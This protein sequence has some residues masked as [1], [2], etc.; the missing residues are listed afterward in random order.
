[1]LN[2]D[3]IE[4]VD[5]SREDALPFVKYKHYAKRVPAMSYLYGLYFHGL[6]RGVCIFGSSANRSN[7]T[8]G[9]SKAIE[10]VRLFVDDEVSVHR[11]MTSY[12]LGKCLKR[13]PRGLAVVSYADCHNNHAGYIYQATNWFYC[14]QGQ[15]KNGR[16]D[17][18]VTSFIRDSDGKKFHAR[19]FADKYGACTGPNAKAHGFTRVFDKPKHKYLYFTG[20]GRATASFF[21][22]LG[23]KQ[24]EYPKTENVRYCVD[25]S[26]EPAPISFL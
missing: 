13:L 14:G 4:V 8:I 9:G 19:S 11:N 15:R 5:I 25:V 20:N 26:R 22:N 17:S 18:G 10:L 7:N 16:F 1:M 21:A 12:F 23:L 6:L 24:Q 2:K 3:D